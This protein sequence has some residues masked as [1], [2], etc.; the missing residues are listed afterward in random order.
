MIVI[1]EECGKKYR[2]DP[3]KMKGETAR[4]KCRNCNHIVSVSKPATN[5]SEPVKEIAEEKP[6][7]SPAKE[8]E[9]IKTVR[10]KTP[11]M[12]GLAKRG[13]GVRG[14]MTLL[15][16]LVPILLMSGAAFFYLTQMETL[17]TQIKDDSART[18]EQMAER[19]IADKADAVAEQV[20]L[21]LDN[22]PDLAK[23]TFNKNPEFKKIAV[24]KVG[25]AGYTT[26]YEIPEGDAIW[27][28]WAHP[29]PKLIGIDM[30]T[31]R[32]SLGKY[33]DGF[34]KIFSGV[35]GGKKSSGYYAWKDPDGKIRDK[36]MVCVPVP[37]TPYAVANTAYVDEF[38]APVKNLETRV[39]ATTT[40]TRNINLG[41]MVGTII[42]IGLFVFI[43]G[44]KL[45]GNIKYL[46]DIA[47]RI[48]V[49]E[50][51]AEIEVKAKDEIGALAEAISR[52]QDSV[53][54][55]V[56]RLRRRR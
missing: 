46:T 11:A 30:K 17:S 50:L 55:S 21:Y 47:D 54:L 53:R 40:T 26:L 44:Q 34:W 25:R 23:E 27:R 22:H 12:P 56:E 35:R 8:K 6:E 15:F 39:K 14:K 51:E 48:S 16:F 32:K 45:S 19:A 41:I 5:I 42:L 10:L 31:L 1:C 7:P 24:Q 4:F 38:R 29:D 43:Y 9:D 13:L 33:F 3:D 37:D 20:K 49:G 28:V 18:I 2:I 36:F 52:M